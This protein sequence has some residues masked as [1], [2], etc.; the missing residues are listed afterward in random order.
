LH[1]ALYKST[2]IIIII[3]KQQ[4][5]CLSLFVLVTC[6]NRAKTAEL[7]KMLFGKGRLELIA[8]ET[9]YGGTQ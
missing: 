8:K 3:D 7:I 1:N 5:V 9:T 6:V 4:S 2:I